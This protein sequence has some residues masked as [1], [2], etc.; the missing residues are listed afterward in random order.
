L[1]WKAQEQR[2]ER[3]IENRP[4][5]PDLCLNEEIFWSRAEAQVVID[6]WREVYNR[7]RP[8]SALDFKTSAEAAKEALEDRKI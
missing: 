4:E 3:L 6:W 1:T 8:H 2:S 7:E 5:R